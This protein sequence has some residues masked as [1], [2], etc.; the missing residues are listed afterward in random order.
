MFQILW[1]SIVLYLFYDTFIYYKNERQFFYSRRILGVRLTFIIN[2]NKIIIQYKIYIIEYE[3]RI[4]WSFFL[5]LGLCISRGTATVLNL[6]GAL[7]L[8]PQC[9]KLNQILYRILSKLWPGLFFFWLEKAKSFHMTVAT[10]LV[11][12]GGEYKIYWSGSEN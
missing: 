6:C 10:T 1:I 9:K 11:I 7:I 8:L 12:F 2:V 3:C 5:Q 4:Y